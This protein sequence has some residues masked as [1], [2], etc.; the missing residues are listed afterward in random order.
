[1]KPN[2][3]DTKNSQRR[4]A[5]RPPATQLPRTMAQ[6]QYD[7]DLRDDFAIAAMQGFIVG[8]NKPNLEFIAE[9]AYKMADAML[10]E[11]KKNR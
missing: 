8:T 5:Q 11:R 6:K 2:K 1:M 4:P 3:P 9:T 10:A 7:E